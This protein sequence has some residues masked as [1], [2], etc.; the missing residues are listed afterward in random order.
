MIDIVLRDMWSPIALIIVVLLMGLITYMIYNLGNPAYKRTKHKGEP[1]IS[2]N[3]P[4]SDVSMIQVGGDNVFWG[5]THAL[6]KY[7]D[8]L[9][10]GHTGIVNDY[11]YWFVITLAL[12]L[13]YVY[14]L[15]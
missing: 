8:P 1:F 5:F 13:I 7:I 15:I 4:P 3:K 9:V 12:V 11:V 6:R 14:I 2:G 10:K